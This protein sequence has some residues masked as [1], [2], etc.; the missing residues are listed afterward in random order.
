MSLSSQDIR[1]R[2]AAVAEEFATTPRVHIYR[3]LDDATYVIMEFARADPGKY[4]GWG[5][6]HVLSHDEAAEKGRDLVTR[7]LLTFSS[8]NGNH[9]TGRLKV[10]PGR[11]SFVQDHNQV[12]A[13]LARDGTIRL[14]PQRRGEVQY[15]RLV[16]SEI[17]LPPRF[18]AA[19]FMDG[20][21]QAFSIG[22]KA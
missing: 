5:K 2:S 16:E 20:V 8:R 3:T 9:K 6:L 7:S 14:M 15:T 12:V 17:V 10:P 22:S 11:G 19:E 4:V 18:D 13:T 1:V 21:D